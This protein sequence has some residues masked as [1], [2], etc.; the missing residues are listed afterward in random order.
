MPDEN[1]KRVLVDTNIWINHL[2]DGNL[3][4]FSDLLIQDQI[5]LSDWVELELLCGTKNKGERAFLTRHFKGILRPAQAVTPP[6]ACRF[7]EDHDLGGR[8]LSAVDAILL[9]EAQTNQA[10]LWTNDRALRRA[11]QS[12]KISFEP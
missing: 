1:D 11:S 6:N 10:L 9:L 12:L 2:Q 3:P 8:G 4:L 5:I 7:I